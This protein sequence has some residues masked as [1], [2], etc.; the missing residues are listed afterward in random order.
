MLGIGN[1]N[2][3][4]K[5]IVLIHFV[6]KGENKWTCLHNALADKGWQQVVQECLKLYVVF[7]KH[8]V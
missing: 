1:H 6:T 4:L 5:D 3:A 2:I 7:S 8:A